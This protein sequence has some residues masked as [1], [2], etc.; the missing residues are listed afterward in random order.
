MSEKRMGSGTAKTVDQYIGGFP[1]AVRRILKPLRAA[2]REAAPEAVEKISYGMPAYWQNRMLVYFAGHTRHVGFYPGVEAV[3]AFKGQL[4]RFATS[5]GTVQFPYEKPIP[6]G[7]VRRIVAA[8]VRACAPAGRSGDTRTRPPRARS[9]R[10]P[11][12]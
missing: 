3:V 8:R 11:R 10:G 4:S 1:P 12:T 2:I 7:L 5:K 9:P 6:L